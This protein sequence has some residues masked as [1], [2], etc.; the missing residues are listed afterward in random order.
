[1]PALFVKG[2]FM[3]N[4]RNFNH[5]DAEI[6]RKLFGT[7][8]DEEISTLLGEW[9]KKIFQGKYFEMF[10]VTYDSTVVGSVSLYAHTKDAISCGPEILHEYRRR[11][12]GYEAAAAA[13]DYAKKNGYKIAVAQVRRNNPAS[14]ALHERLGF[15]IDHEFTNKKGSEVYFYIKSLL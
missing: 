10:A 7:T 13:L 8:S 4:I 5:N 15:E 9:N 11:G 6:I 14:I 3:V 1:M 12:F 2:K